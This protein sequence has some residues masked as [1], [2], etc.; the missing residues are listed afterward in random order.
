MPISSVEIRN[1]A[2]VR[3]RARQ[4]SNVAEQQLLLERK[5]NVAEASEA[6]AKRALAPEARIFLAKVGVKNSRLEPRKL[7]LRHTQAEV[8]MTDKERAEL[9]HLEHMER[10][11]QVK[12]ILGCVCCYDA[13]FISGS[14]LFL[15]LRQIT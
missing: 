3:K 15:C 8:P 6:V 13:I 4:Q 14:E 2:R 7:H 11:A 12:K 5:T 9:E 10:M 1:L